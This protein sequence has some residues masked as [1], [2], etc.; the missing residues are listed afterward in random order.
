M[1]KDIR[2]FAQYI[3]L[4]EMIVV[5]CQEIHHVV[6]P[7]IVIHCRE[8]EIQNVGHARGKPGPKKRKES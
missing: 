7:N 6:S 5:Y 1:T 3:Y 8:E 2:S 4:A